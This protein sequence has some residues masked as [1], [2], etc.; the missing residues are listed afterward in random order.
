MSGRRSAAAA[1]VA[2]ATLMVVA[3][4]TGT[5]PH[6]DGRSPA[7]TPSAACKL[8]VAEAGFTPHKAYLSGQRVPNNDSLRVG[9][10]VKNPCEHAAANV[11][12]TAFGL[13]ASG[14][15]I[16]NPLDE[17]TTIYADADV[18][19]IPAGATVA[20]GAG[21]RTTDDRGVT[22]PAFAK[23]AKFTVTARP[24]CWTKSTGSD[25][26]VPAAS[27]VKVGTTN[28]DGHRADRLANVTFRTAAV[29]QT[30]A[31]RPAVV[32]RDKGGRLLDVEEGSGSYA[33]ATPLAGH[34]VVSVWVPANADPSRAE[35]MLRPAPKDEPSC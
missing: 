6:S 23:V 16:P 9:I 27:D 10:L 12:V 7:A 21:M 3:G 5:K 31:T 17:G 20:I 35:V 33:T 15:H 13:D 25:V 24:A 2:L 11:H 19:L 28:A 14:H 8:S 26:R 22:Q 1:G 30:S 29:K 18:P 32:F 34:S 4:C